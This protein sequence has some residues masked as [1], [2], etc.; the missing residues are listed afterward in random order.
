[1]QIMREDLFKKG[2]HGTLYSGSI[3]QWRCPERDYEC[4]VRLTQCTNGTFLEAEQ[5]GQAGLAAKFEN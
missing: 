1:M 5:H 4:L 3:Q 2:E